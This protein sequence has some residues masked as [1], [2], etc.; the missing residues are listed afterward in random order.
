MGKSSFGN[1]H[2]TLMA[3]AGAP[4]LPACGVLSAASGTLGS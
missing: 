3:G 2:F 1:A 4:E